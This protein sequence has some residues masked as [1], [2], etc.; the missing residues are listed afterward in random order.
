VLLSVTGKVHRRET[1]QSG[2][3]ASTLR[4]DYI[5]CVPKQLDHQTQR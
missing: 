2:F 3:Q 4:V 1:I 5:H